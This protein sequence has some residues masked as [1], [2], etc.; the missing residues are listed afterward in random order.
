MDPFEV[1]MQFL[2]LLSRLTSS[3]QSQ[4]RVALFAL[5]HASR[6]SED[7]WDCYL[8]EVGQPD[9]RDGQG[10][11]HRIDL[12]YLVDAILDR[13]GP[14]L[15]T[16]GRSTATYRTLVERDL[17]KV[18][19]EVVPESREGLLNYMSAM[20]VL[21]SWRTRRLLDPDV[22]DAVTVQLEARKASLHAKASE[23]ATSAS[24]SSSSTSTTFSRNDI[25]RRIEDDRERHKR[26][27]ERIWVLPIPTT[28]YNAPLLLAPGSSGL[29]PSSTT[30][31]QGNHLYGSTKPSPISP[32][33][34]FE[35]A[36]AGP[37]GGVGTYSTG[38]VAPG[39]SGSTGPGTG[40]G[41][42]AGGGGDKA[43]RSSTTTTTTTTTGPEVALELEF[44][45][46]WDA[47]EQERALAVQT[48]SGSTLGTRRLD[49]RDE[50]PTGRGT[51]K[52]RRTRQ[53][54]EL[55]EG[56]KRQLDDESRRC[57]ETL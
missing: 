3:V 55:H 6:C 54:W 51:A 31:I 50:P 28:I 30:T 29:D 48:A 18:V 13:E 27:R 24:S 17:D 42:G 49:E 39:T 19:N 16:S 32:A 53:V 7:V 1:R 52:R 20:Q 40:G 15:V 22:L 33:S 38:S 11:N 36:A 57:F 41:V 56:E 43:A 23:E 37:G 14:L 46:L 4:S 35:P 34:P 12:L 26:L 2:S 45:Q 44:E 25:L 21:K 9:Q 5:K 8:D 10:L 47:V